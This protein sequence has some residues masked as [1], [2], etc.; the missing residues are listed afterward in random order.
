MEEDK[1]R[2]YKEIKNRY[3]T[4]LENIYTKYTNEKQKYENEIETFKKNI[5]ATHQAILLMEEKEKELDFHRLLLDSK[6]QTDIPILKNLMEKISAPRAI[7]SMIWSSYYLPIAQIIFPKILGGKDISGI[8]LI[9]NIENEKIYIGQ[10]KNIQKRWYD[11]CRCGIGI[12]TPVNNKLYQDMLKYG[13]EN[14]AFYLLQETKELDEREKYY[15]EL[16]ESNIYGYNM[17]TGG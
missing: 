3:N 5:Q 15:I 14:F 4:A 2:E 9:R 13:L 8:Y 6:K 10:A 17:K 11:H 12:D 7:A 1:D 16:F